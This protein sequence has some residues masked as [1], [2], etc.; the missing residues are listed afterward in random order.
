MGHL[1]LDQFRRLARRVFLLFFVAACASARPEV[2]P[3]QTA[4]AQ[5]LTARPPASPTPLQTP[6]PQPN[7]PPTGK[8]VYVCQYSKHVNRNQICLINADGSGQRILTPGGAYDDF[9]PSITPDGNAVLFTSSRTGRYQLYEYDLTNDSLTQLTTLDDFSPFAP[10]ASPDGSYIV[11]YAIADGRSYPSSH[12]IW[13][14][15]RDGSNPTQITH[16]AGGGWDPV[17]SPEGTQIQFASEVDGAV[18]LFHVNVDGSDLTQVTH[19]SGIRGRNDWSRDGQ[20]LAT[21]RGSSWNWEIYVFDTNG[22]NVRQ[23]TF[24]ADSLAPSFSPDSRWIAFMSYRDHPH[25][26]LGCEIYIMRTDGSDVR[27]L[28]DNDICDWQPRWGP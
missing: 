14:M 24:A 26:D 15:A 13:V 17:W 5:T 10:A 3:V 8:I 25:Q 20:L 27:R 7:A 4:M 9:F 6:T 1:G 23:L 22:E 11:F 16:L 28:T 19:L 21:Y 18:Q 12:N 2:N